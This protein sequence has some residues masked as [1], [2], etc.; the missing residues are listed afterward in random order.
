MRLI[1]LQIKWS[2][3]AFLMGHQRFVNVELLQAEFDGSE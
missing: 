1:T 2:W 3:R